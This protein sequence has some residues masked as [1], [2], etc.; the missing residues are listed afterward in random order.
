[1]TAFSN[2]KKE[3]AAIGDRGLVSVLR[4]AG[5]KKTCVISEDRNVVEAI[6]KAL[7][8]WLSDPAVG[9]IILLEEFAEAAR[10]SISRYRRSKRALP[11]IV[12]VPSKKGTRQP[13]AASYYKQFSRDCLGFDIEL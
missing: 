6:E 4:L 9:V 1:M 3:I 11:V 2:A 5:V 13:D 10:D 7:N 8:E 12:P